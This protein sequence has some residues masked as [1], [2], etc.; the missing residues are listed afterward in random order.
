MKTLK[1]AKYYKIIALEGYTQKKKK[2]TSYH[3]PTPLTYRKETK[4]LKNNVS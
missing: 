4:T 1:E 3:V 2:N